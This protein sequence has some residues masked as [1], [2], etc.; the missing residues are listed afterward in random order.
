M[1]TFELEESDF[2]GYI[3]DGT[4]KEARVVGVKVAKKPFT[5]DEGKDVHKVEFKFAVSDPDGIFDGQNLW[6]ETGTK[7]NTHP[8]CKLRNWSSA[9]LGTELPV[10][11]TL[12]TDLLIGH[13]CRISIEL[14]EYED[15]KAGVDPTTGNKPM[16]QRNRV[17]DVFPTAAAMA[18]MSSG[19]PGFGDEEP[20]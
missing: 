8:D 2:A 18:S 4:I 19:A 7:F 13:D 6:G 15:K 1:A 3:P 20:F 17:V 14:Y 5:D 16:K 9:I 10:G 12:D 11:Y